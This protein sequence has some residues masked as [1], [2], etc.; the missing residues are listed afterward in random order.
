V[1]KFSSQIKD[2]IG[3]KAYSAVVNEFSTTTDIITTSLQFTLLAS[4]KN[5]FDYYCYTRCG[6]SKVKM[7]GTLEDWV[8]LKEKI[9]SLEQFNL[10]NWTNKLKDI[11]DKF[12]E[13]K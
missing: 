5:F 9:M 2:I 11:L 8:F 10:E 6:I 7:T 13:Q 1:Q 12:I 3:E 4:M